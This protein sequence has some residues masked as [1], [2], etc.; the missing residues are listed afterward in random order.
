MSAAADEIPGGTE[1]L[2]VSLPSHVARALRVA[3]EE[4]HT[5]VSGWVAESIRDRLLVLGM[6]AYIADY[7]REFGEITDE[8]IAAVRREVEERSAPWR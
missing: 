3:A 1:R 2:T 7:E 8:E 5:S 6:K 4:E